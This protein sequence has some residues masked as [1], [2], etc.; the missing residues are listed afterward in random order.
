MKFLLFQNIFW[1]SQV[2]SLQEWG[3]GTELCCEPEC[4]FASLCTNT[5][6]EKIQLTVLLKWLTNLFY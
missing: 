4:K 3:S 6:R 5:E 2:S 1:T